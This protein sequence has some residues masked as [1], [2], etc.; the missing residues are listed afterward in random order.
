MVNVRPSWS[1][2]SRRLGDCEAR[3]SFVDICMKA[4]LLLIERTINLRSV[5]ANV[6]LAAWRLLENESC[7]HA[8]IGAFTP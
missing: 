2:R 4:G 7:R 1:S 6:D 3:I 5:D 8:K